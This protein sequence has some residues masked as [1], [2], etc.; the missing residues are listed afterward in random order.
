MVMVLLLVVI[1][2]AAVVDRRWR[3]IQ[4]THGWRR[5]KLDVS[6]AQFSV[7]TGRL[8]RCHCLSQS[9]FLLLEISITFFIRSY[10]RCRVEI[11]LISFD[12]RA[13]YTDDLQPLCVPPVDWNLTQ[14]FT[15]SSH[16]LRHKSDYPIPLYQF[17]GLFSHRLT[18]WVPCFFAYRNF[19]L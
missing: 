7:F 3:S 18:G 2:T 1:E 14:Q 13:D 12:R 8:V 15:V 4:S 17:I 19:F 11:L 5:G 9:V 16:L 6:A 10:Q